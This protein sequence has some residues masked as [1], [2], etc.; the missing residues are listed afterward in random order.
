MQKHVNLLKFLELKM[1]KKCNNILKV[2][3]G[4]WF[5]SGWSLNEKNVY[6]VENGSQIVSNQLFL[7]HKEL[8]S[9]SST[10]TSLVSREENWICCLGASSGWGFILSNDWC[11]SQSSVTRN[12]KL[13]WPVIIKGVFFSFAMSILLMIRIKSEVLYYT[14]PPSY[15]EN[16]LTRNFCNKEPNYI[17][18]F[19][20]LLLSAFRFVPKMGRHNQFSDLLFRIS[21]VPLEAGSENV[22]MVIL[23]LNLNS[24]NCLCP[25]VNF[26]W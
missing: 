3:E 16:W 9:P 7:T 21:R 4:L 8:L 11:G 19:W 10:N 12:F 1:F 18:I 6:V 26:S 13:D 25:F 5:F 2:K 23:G 22:R 14:K 15:L 20:V 17:Q 24:L